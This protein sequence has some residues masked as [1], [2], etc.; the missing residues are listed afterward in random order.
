M[1]THLEPGSSPV[2]LTVPHDG[3]IKIFN[4]PTRRETQRW[5]QEGIKDSRDR[6]TLNLARSCRSELGLFGIVPSV[7]YTYLH[8]S[9]ADANR[10]LQREP[11]A[12]GFMESYEAFHALL[13]QEVSTIITRHKFCIL[14]DI[15]GYV[16]SPGPEIYDIVFGSDSHRTCPLKTD[17]RMVDYLKQVGSFNLNRPWRIVF[18]PDHENRIMS[19]HRGGWIVRNTARIYGN[20]GLD[21]MQ[22]EFNLHMRQ[23]PI[24]TEIAS[25]LAVAIRRI[26]NT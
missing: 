17:R 2:I 18:S 25:Q 22:L 7:L 24:R 10:S 6:G 21:S 4:A 1:F 9:H 23:E 14:L 20:C 13:D 11:Y 8:R 26:I 16:N 3:G 15:H 19:K 12:D 5:E